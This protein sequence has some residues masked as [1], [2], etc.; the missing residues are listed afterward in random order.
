MRAFTLGLLFLMATLTV[1]GQDEEFTGWMKSAGRAAGTLGKLEKKTGKDAV[2]SAEQL[3]AVYENMIGFWRQRNAADAVKWSEEGK[4]AA[5]ILASAANSGDEAK[6][7]EA[8]K[9][10]GATCKPCHAAHREKNAEGQ[11]RIK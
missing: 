9:S 10:V 8:F 7:A 11:Y 4:A 1:A 5:V 2:Q 6:A 3:G